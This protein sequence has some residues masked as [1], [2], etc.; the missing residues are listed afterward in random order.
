MLTLGA[1]ELA[2]RWLAPVPYATERNMY[3]IADPFTGYR[4]SPF[5]KGQ[6]SGG[7]P[8]NANLH[9][10][11][12]DDVSLF[13][14]PGVFR[15][16]VLGDSFT[17]GASVEQRDSYPAQLQRLLQRRTR[18]RI[19]VMNTAVGGWG[20]LQYA[21][22]F[23][24]YGLEFDPDMVIVGLFVGNDITDSVES[25]AQ[26]PTAALGRRISRKASR[27]PLISLKVALHE[28][29][30]LARLVLHQARPLLDFRRERCDEFPSVFIQIQ[31]H[32]TKIYRTDWQQRD[33]KLARVTR[34]IARIEAHARDFGI[35]LLVVLIADETQINPALQRLLFKDGEPI[36]I[37]QPQRLLTER[38]A[39]KGIETLDL[40]P[41]F[42][43]YPG[44]LHQ[45]DTHW[46]R[47][48]HRLAAQEILRA[49][50]PRVSAGLRDRRGVRVRSGGS[51]GSG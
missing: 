17:V 32:R 2:L 41:A 13:K 34:Q 15:I 1:V 4:L 18:R 48:G 50:A 11:R 46:T 16:L 31:R 43:A 22:Y 49:I 21:Q 45:N 12:S 42:R 8:A 33:V 40:L 6:F 19:E 29:S 5:G 3:Y 9:G 26:L 7:I 51:G 38:F 27:D 25:I 39:T 10:H 44:C 37:D 35:P 30:H 36:D 24:H 47:D 28:S 14:E 20:P 23:A